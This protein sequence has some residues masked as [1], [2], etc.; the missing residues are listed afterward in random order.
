MR[1]P[2]IT[3][4]GAE[5]KNAPWHEPPL[6]SI[7]RRCQLRLL[8]TLVTKALPSRKEDPRGRGRVRFCSSSSPSRGESPS[9]HLGSLYTWFWDSEWRFKDVPRYARLKPK[10]DPFF[11]I[12]PDWNLYRPSFLAFLW[13]SRLKIVSTKRGHQ[14]DRSTIFKKRIFFF[15]LKRGTEALTHLS[16]EYMLGSI[17]QSR[18]STH[19]LSMTCAPSTHVPHTHASHARAPHTCAPGI[20]APHTR[21]PRTRPLHAHA[22]YTYLCSPCLCSLHP[23]FTHCAPCTHV[24]SSSSLPLISSVHPS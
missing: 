9:R 5:H 13:K 11:Q 6:H 4:P 2:N 10:R 14:E 12:C 16:T 3:S 15:F 20:R 22:P 8:H 19:M 23:C 18:A 24:C 21:S 17:C 7:A 1:I